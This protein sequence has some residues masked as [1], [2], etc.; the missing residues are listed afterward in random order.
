MKPFR[1]SLTA[2]QSSMFWFVCLLATSP[3]LAAQPKVTPMFSVTAGTATSTGGN[4]Y[5]RQSLLAEVLI[6]GRYLPTRAVAP[7][8][9]AV[10][11]RAFRVGSDVRCAL[12]PDGSCIPN[13]PN[14]TYGAVVV[15]ASARWKNLTLLGAAG[16]AF[17]LSS[18]G[19][20]SY[21]YPP[22]GFGKQVLGK[23]NPTEYGLMSRLDASL[24]VLT[25][26]ALTASASSRYVPSFRE[27]PLRINGFAI[28]VQFH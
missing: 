5:D 18:E 26:I 27:T 15:G 14:F 2:S 19:V 22:G 3:T 23:S 28:G 8:F 13:M 20:T 24:P 1:L 12:A 25:H 11:G 6:A 10:G 4:Y 16:P 7:V 17:F 21:W 9:G